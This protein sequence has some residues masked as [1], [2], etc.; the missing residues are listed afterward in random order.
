[1]CKIVHRTKPIHQAA[2]FFDPPVIHHGRYI[3]INARGRGFFDNKRAIKPLGHLFPG[4]VMRMIPKGSGVRRLKAI[5]ERA[6]WRN[7]GLGHARHAVHCV[8]Q[9]DA[10]PM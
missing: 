9:T 4:S 3:V 1:M 5:V 2:G 7:Q 6:A 8:I 10:M